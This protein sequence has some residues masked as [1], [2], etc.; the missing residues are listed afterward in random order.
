MEACIDDC[1]QQM[2]CS[3]PGQQERRTGRR[4]LDLLRQSLGLR[5]TRISLERLHD[6]SPPTVSTAG[7]SAQELAAESE[8]ALRDSG[9]TGGPPNF[10]DLSAGDLT[11]ARNPTEDCPQAGE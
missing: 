4:R 8:A 6:R 1:A 3:T 9:G 7:F 11:A 2:L 5:A 10:T